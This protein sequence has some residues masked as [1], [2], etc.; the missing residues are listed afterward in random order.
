MNTLVLAEQGLTS[1]PENLPSGLTNL[2]C[3][4]NQLTSLPDSLPSGLTE[5]YCSRNQLTYLPKVSETCR[6]LGN[7]NPWIWCARIRDAG[8]IGLSKN[9][10]VKV[11]ILVCKYFARQLATK[12]IHR[13]LEKWLDKPITNDGKLGIRLRINLREHCSHT[14]LYPPE[15]Q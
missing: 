15:S 3:G 5:L 4:G 10:V 12:I 13:N 1:L 8:K 6:I 2:Y 14:S 9:K 7:N 11:H